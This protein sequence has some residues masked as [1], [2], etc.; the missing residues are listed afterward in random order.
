MRPFFSPFRVSSLDRFLTRN[1]LWLSTANILA[2]IECAYL[3][4]SANHDISDK[5]SLLGMCV[6]LSS[7]WVERIGVSREAR[8]KL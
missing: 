4:E 1:V 6:A 7:E 8:W 5:Q 2:V 3:E